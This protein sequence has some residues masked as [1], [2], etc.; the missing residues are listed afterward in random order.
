MVRKISMRGET[1]K[2]MEGGIS[3]N[4]NHKATSLLLTLYQHFCDLA[5]PANEHSSGS[6]QTFHASRF[7]LRQIYIAGGFKM[8]MNVCSRGSFTIHN[9]RFERT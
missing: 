8:D 7:V 2:D 1:L 9:L 3:N 4:Q 5:S 6:P